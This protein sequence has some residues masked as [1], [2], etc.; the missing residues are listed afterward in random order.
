MIT[1][2]DSLV[3]EPYLEFIDFY[4]KAENKYQKNI[5]AACLSTYNINKSE[6]SSRYVNIKYIQKDGFIFFT[7]YKS[8]KSEDISLHPKC[9]L[10]FLWNTTNTQI[11]LKG[12]IKKIPKKDSDQHFLKRTLEKNALAISSNQSNEISS[13]EKVIDNFNNQLDD[14]KLNKTDISRPDYW[15]GYMFSP[16]YFEF[17]EGN[18]FRLNKRFF[19]KKENKRW[20]KKKYLEP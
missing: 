20:D 16:T 6:V 7:N 15:G 9:A 10:L 2:I 18:D 1:F 17:W 19:Y 4:K 8:P 13:Y 12:E 5:Q 11:R 3:D 14:M